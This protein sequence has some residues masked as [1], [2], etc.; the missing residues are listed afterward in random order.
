MI[1]R[2]RLWLQFFRSGCLWVYRVAGT[3]ISHRTVHC[4]LWAEVKSKAA[5]FWNVAPYSLAEI[6]RRFKGAY[7]LQQATWPTSQKT[8]IFSLIAVRIWD[9]TQRSD[10][11]K[12]KN[13]GHL[14]CSSWLNVVDTNYKMKPLSLLRYDSLMFLN[15]EFQ[16]KQLRK[17]IPLNRMTFETERERSEINAL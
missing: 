8:A 1:R 3:N 16:D 14:A 17:C 7:C 6:E 5:V 4:L 10:L 9:V 11:L 13:Q 15:V 2:V 12:E